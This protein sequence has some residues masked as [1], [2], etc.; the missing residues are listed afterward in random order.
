MNRDCLPKWKYIHTYNILI[1]SEFCEGR[2]CIVK[3]NIIRLF[4]LLP[5]YCWFRFDSFWPGYTNIWNFLFLFFFVEFVFV[6]STLL[7]FFPY[8][9]Q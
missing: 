6:N 1:V 7:V 4:L 3:K 2:R 9:K 5:F 8:E